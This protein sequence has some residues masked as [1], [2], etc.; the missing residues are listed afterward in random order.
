MKTGVI[1]LSVFAAGWA[2][3][4]LI[5]IDA[6]GWLWLLP[7]AISTAL[8]SVCWRL[9][10]PVEDPLEGKRIGR[11][12][13]LWSAVEGVTIFVA[14]NVVTWLGQPTMIGPATCGIVGLHFIPLAR[15]MQRPIYNVT[16]AVMVL[17]RVMAIALPASWRL[18]AVG[19]AGSATLWLTSLSII[20][21]AQRRTSSGR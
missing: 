11:L 8:A 14:A 18:S 3:A 20:Q 15:G 12:V 10:L 13:G 5:S 7:I 6:A 17:A 1:V 2:I 21:Q 4:G 16:G 19:L 9:V